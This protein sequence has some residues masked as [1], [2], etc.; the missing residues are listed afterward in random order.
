MGFRNLELDTLS[1]VK[2]TG[3]NWLNFLF[4]TSLDK[5][6]TTQFCDMVHQISWDE[7]E[8]AGLTAGLMMQ[9]KQILQKL[10]DFDIA[11]LGS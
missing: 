10:L 4:L 8:A 1:D 11:G 9:I 3:K 7:S 2:S 5:T 6:K